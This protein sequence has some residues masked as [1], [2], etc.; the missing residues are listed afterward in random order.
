VQF[1]QQ[2]VVHRGGDGRVRPPLQ[3]RQE[4]KAGRGGCTDEGA[5]AT[6]EAQQSP[7]DA[8]GAALD[9]LAAATRPELRRIAAVKL[10]TPE[11]SS[12]SCSAISRLVISGPPAT[13]ARARLAS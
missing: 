2:A 13:L 1:G 4:G 7:R 9:L 6:E 12:S 11:T 10:A 8:V 3:K 5:V